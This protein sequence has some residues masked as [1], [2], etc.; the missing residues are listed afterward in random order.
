LHGLTR[1]V[2]RLVSTWPLRRLVR[3][4]AS[5]STEANKSFAYKLVE[6][7]F[8]EWSNK[9]CRAKTGGTASSADVCARAHGHAIALG[10]VAEGG[11]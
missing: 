11:P 10:L 4:R 1:K 5:H 3:G 7:F 2:C 9:I 8:F 6:D